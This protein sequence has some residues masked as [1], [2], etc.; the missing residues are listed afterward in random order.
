MSKPN[1]TRASFV[2]A[3]IVAWAGVVWPF[4]GSLLLATVVLAA[5]QLYASRGAA[6][7]AR[8]AL[9]LLFGWALTAYQ[10]TV[11]PSAG[12]LIHPDFPLAVGAVVCALALFRRKGPDHV[13]RLALLAV[14]AGL[15]V[16]ALDRE[17][18]S[19]YWRTKI[20]A[21]K[22]S[23]GLPHVAWRDVAAE[24]FGR[25]VSRRKVQS[26]GW[27]Q[28]ID[29]K[30]GPYGDL[31]LYRTK[32][33]DFWA[34]AA[35]RESVALIAL[36][37]TE[38]DDYEIDAARI[39]PGETV[40]DCGAHV[41]F[42]S[43]LALSRGAGMVVAVEP[44]PEN[45]WCLR[46]NL[47]EEIDE[48]R[49]RLIQAGVWDERDSL[50]FYHSDSN[51]GAHGF[52][53]RDSEATTYQDVPVLPIDDLVAQLELQRVDWIKMDIEGAEARALLGAAGVLS[54]YKPKLAVCTYH[55]HED[56]E[57]I[58]PIVLRANADY[59]ISAKRIA[60]DGVVR[61]KVLFFH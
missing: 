18:V 36:E 6:A 41:G 4:T 15:A 47:K 45:Y 22:I 13:A 23:G 30:T 40:I 33:G 34:S 10:E 49:V 28:V 60:A 61:P 52:F 44:D 24:A 17:G 35:N 21:V 43:K 39:Q 5:G 7:Y 1:A 19:V 3:V 14:I 11:D 48:G 57:V 20:L 38:L 46:E 55:R 12:P 53:E 58:P 25:R 51:P 29:R 59:E 2:V 16:S 50:T 27:I 54:R 26:G 32:L 8:A 42:Y 37:M 56:S 9:F 31:E